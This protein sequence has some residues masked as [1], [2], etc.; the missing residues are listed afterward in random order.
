MI[1]I[2]SRSPGETQKVARMLAREIHADGTRRAGRPRG[3]VVVALS[4]ELGAGKTTFTQG[5]ARA[6][7][8]RE[9][10]QSPTFVLMKIYDLKHEAVSAKHEYKYLVHI[11]CYRI[12]G[13]KDLIHLG[14]KDMLRDQDATILIE[15]PERIKKIIPS[16]ALWLFF[17]HGAG[18]HERSIQIK[19]PA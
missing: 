16:N 15:W 19:G 1:D 12:H 7:G 2:V 13:P 10:I 3:A 8:I 18:V 17:G 4:G 14:L 6:L 9:K 5:F 11:D